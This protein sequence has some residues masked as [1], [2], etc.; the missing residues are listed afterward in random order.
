MQ[1][2]P[3]GVSNGQEGVQPALKRPPGS[4]RGACLL[5][6]SVSHAS[7]GRWQG[8]EPAAESLKPLS[9]LARIR[10]LDR[11]TV[12]YNRGFP[13]VIPEAPKA[14]GILVTATLCTIGTDH[15][16]MPIERYSLVMPLDCAAPKAKHRNLIRLGA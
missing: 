1:A 10:G 15:A 2:Q 8:R 13:H 9:T 11:H 12:L 16:Q 3:S 4:R 7:K 14:Y 5:V 6:Y